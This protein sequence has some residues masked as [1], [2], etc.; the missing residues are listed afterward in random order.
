MLHYTVIQEFQ[1]KQVD[2]STTKSVFSGT[3][4]FDLH[5][6][7]IIVDPI[8]PWTIK[9]YGPAVIDAASVVAIR[10]VKP[11]PV[12]DETEDSGDED[13]DRKG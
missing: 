11:R 1:G 13:C 3:L 5:K 8:D 9:R 2:V 10:E 12:H 6:G 7:V 4:K